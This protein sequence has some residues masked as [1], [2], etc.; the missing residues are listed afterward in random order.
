MSH[1]AFL[2]EIRADPEDTI[3]RLIYADWLEENGDPLAELI[4]VQCELAEMDVEADGRAELRNR[5]RELLADYEQ[6]FVE[7]L[8]RFAPHG[9]E[10]R[11]G[12][13]EELRID[14][15]TFF[16]HASEIVSLLPALCSLNLR[17]ARKSLDE[18]V[19]LPELQRVRFLD[20]R[21][22]DL[23]DAGL[24]KL[25]ESP[26]LR[27]LVELNL[28]GNSLSTKGVQALATSDSLRGLRSLKLGAN[29]LTVTACRALATSPV[30]RDL[31]SLSLWSTGLS[32]KGIARLAE[33]DRLSGLTRMDIGSNRISSTGIQTLANGPWNLQSLE[34]GY[35][36]RF[37]VE[38][39]QFL[40]NGESMRELRHL[41]MINAPMRLAGLAALLTSP[42]MTSLESLSV[43]H[44]GESSTIRAVRQI[45]EPVAAPSLRIV[46]LSHCRIH[47]GGLKQI[48]KSGALANVEDLSLFGNY[49]L[50]EAGISAIT[51]SDQFEHLRQLDLGACGF[52]AA[53]LRTI[54]KWERLPHLHSLNLSGNGY[55]P[56]AVTERLADAVRDSGTRV[57]IDEPGDS[58]QDTAPDSPAS[59][60]WI[61]ASRII[62][63]GHS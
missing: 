17:K 29:R 2:D 49:D 13:I 10:I 58:H 54:A 24:R 12:F 18:L 51:S 61:E 20:L 43:Q 59:K 57:T 56:V 21:M 4:R 40:A 62:N 50:G 45:A 1:D 8:R 52:N 44:V 7:P 60:R 23:G 55:K 16:E 3:P 6:R 14:T 28:H 63:Q 26:H 39:A 36:D 34:A 25:L 15:Q 48:L 32:D 37:G 31:Q 38:A 35:N 9:I 27:D 53:G 41:R 47:A 19:H 46:S 5:E 42:A 11:R 30:L 22:A 33:T